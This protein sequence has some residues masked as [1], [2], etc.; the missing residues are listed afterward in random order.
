MSSVIYIYIY[1]YLTLDLAMPVLVALKEEK[2]FVD[3]ELG[4][5][6]GVEAKEG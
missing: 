3:S 1:I 4:I 2:G 5:G 6:V